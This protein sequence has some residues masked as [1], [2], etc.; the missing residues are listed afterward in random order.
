VVLL[1]GA[2]LVTPLCPNNLHHNAGRMV[3]GEGSWGGE[4]DA[5]V[6]VVLCCVS[7]LG[8]FFELTHIWAKTCLTNGILG[9]VGKVFPRGSHLAHLIK[10]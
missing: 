1:I 9:I 5:M 2:S 6:R 8:I 4:K 7:A 3:G 10:A